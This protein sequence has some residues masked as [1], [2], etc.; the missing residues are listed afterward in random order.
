[1]HGRHAC[2]LRFYFKI[3]SKILSQIFDDLSMIKIFLK[4][5]KL[6]FLKRMQSIMTIIT[7]TN[8]LDILIDHLVILFDF[9]FI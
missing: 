1:M 5:I 8:V 9:F 3:S 6:F 2:S 7:F 4:S